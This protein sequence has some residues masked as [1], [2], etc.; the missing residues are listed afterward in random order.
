VEENERLKKVRYFFKNS[1]QIKTQIKFAASIGINQSSLSSFEKNR[2]IS[3]Q[4]KLL[5]TVIHNV[6]IHWLETG[7]GNMFA[8]KQSAA[9]YLHDQ[10]AL[11]GDRCY[12][13]FTQIKEI[14]DVA[15][16]EKINIYLEIIFNSIDNIIK[17]HLFI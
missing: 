13:F 9:E 15:V 3:R 12:N 6:N 11:N 17:C 5:L 16:L 14:K 4:T 2:K 8:E 7:E 10:I 1:G